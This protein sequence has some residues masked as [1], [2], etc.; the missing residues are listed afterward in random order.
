MTHVFPTRRSSDLVFTLFC[1]FC[2]SQDALI[3]YVDPFIGTGGH[4]HTFPG[5]T[6]PFGMV[7]LSPDN[8][9]DGWD[10]CSGYHY[11]DSLIAG[12]S[13]MH[14]SGT[15]IG[16]WLD[17][18]VMPLIA[19][20]ADTVTS[21]KTPFTHTNE[22]ASPGYYGVTLDNGIHAELTT[23]ARCGLHKYTFPAGSTPTIRLDL[24][25]QQNWDTP[26][27][28]RSE[29]RSVGKEYVSTCRTRWSPY[30]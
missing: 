24:A 17:I 30:T 13:H 23:T 6:V 9:R 19:P 3:S 26:T 22:T 7:Q 20:L 12:F 28:S 5:A 27:E 18:S 8:G 25:F 29:E 15:G 14:L 2:W 21:A 4:G 11:S 1:T 16:D 10:W